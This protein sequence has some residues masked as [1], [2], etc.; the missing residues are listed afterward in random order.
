MAL[1]CKHC[2]KKGISILTAVAYV[3]DG[4]MRCRFCGRESALRKPL[5]VIFSVLEGTGILLGTIYSIFLLAIWPLLASI[6]FAAF[7][8]I[9]IAP[10]FARVKDT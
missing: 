1:N 2:S 7:S 9:V 5:K 3:S 4:S 8:R 10:R 6:A